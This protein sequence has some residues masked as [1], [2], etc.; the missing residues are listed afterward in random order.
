MRRGRAGEC[1][2]VGGCSEWANI[3]LARKICDVMD[4][5]RP[6]AAPHRDLITFVTDRPG[7]DWRYAI[8]I[9]KIKEELGWEPQETFET[10]IR[11]T[12]EWYCAGVGIRAG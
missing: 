12:V 3:D 9:T 7:H 1:Y 2:N 11:K 10:G 8:D 4:E 6:A 5:V